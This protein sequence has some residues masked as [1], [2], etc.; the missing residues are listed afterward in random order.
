MM[1]EAGYHPDFAITMQRRM[2]MR[3]GDKS[4]FMAFFS[5]HPRW[6]TREKRT[7]RVYNEALELFQSRW[8]D[9]DQTSGGNPP[10]IATVEAISA[11]QDKINK[12]A[13][14]QVNL[15]IR[16]AHGHPITVAALFTKNN[17]PVL[18]ALDEYR[19][20]S[21]QLLLWQRIETTS[22][23]ESAQ[24]TLVVPTRALGTKHRKLEVSV[25][26]LSGDEVLEI[27]KAK[28][29]SFPKP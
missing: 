23:I 1:V 24:L 11:V 15:T 14:I 5:D 9:A 17:Q 21:G 29:V 10:A 19:G 18:A 2:R 13:V 25:A 12:T 26:I 3:A 20:K 27:S 28:K 4:K 8:P 22:A 7:L 6:A 16:N